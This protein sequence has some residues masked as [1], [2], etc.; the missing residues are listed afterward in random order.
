MFIMQRSSRKLS[1]VPPLAMKKPRSTGRTSEG[2]M[3]TP[4]SKCAIY[5]TTLDKKLSVKQFFFIIKMTY[6][7]KGFQVKINLFFQRKA[8]HIFFSIINYTF[9]K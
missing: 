4:S 9:Y 2:V 6:N 8:I 1:E 5:N 7:L 3:L